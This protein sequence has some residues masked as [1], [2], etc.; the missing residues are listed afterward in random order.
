VLINNYT[1]NYL[2]L[3]LFYFILF[4]S[5]YQ[6]I[7]EVELYLFSALLFVFSSEAE[8]L[9]MTSHKRSLKSAKNRMTQPKPKPRN[10]TIGTRCKKIPSTID[11]ISKLPDHLLHHILS[12]LPQKQA[13][14]TSILSHRW[15]NVWASMQGFNFYM[16]EFAMYGPEKF[17]SYVNA[18]LPYRLKQDLQ[19]F[20]TF[21]F[22]ASPT[23][24]TASSRW[25]THALKHDVRV[26]HI[27]M[28]LKNSGV[29]A[30]LSR[31]MLTSQSLEELAL[32]C[33]PKVEIRIPNVISLSQLK[34][35]S[36]QRVDVNSTFLERIISGCP[37]LEN[38]NLHHCRV[39]FSEI[40]SRVLRNLVLEHCGIQIQ[41][42]KKFCIFTP[43]LV[44]LR[45]NQGHAISS[46][47]VKVDERV[48]FVSIVASC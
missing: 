30:I 47:H 11:R 10:K 2:L 33:F 40:S 38:L 48:C 25:I 23:N 7:F 16:D 37:R 6:S 21:L 44:Y 1:H 45:F 27:I 34:D 3:F 43:N 19:V 29:K 26:L 42:D 13:G 14:C 36:L 22:S 18:T 28:R 15:R 17:V 9:N 41:R 32:F 39:T 20:K 24:R 8:A 46:H 35:L 5:K 4:L 31:R 12:F